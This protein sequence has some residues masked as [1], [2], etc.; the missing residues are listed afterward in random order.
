MDP[1]DLITLKPRLG[2]YVFSLLFVFTGVFSFRSDLLGKSFLADAEVSAGEVT[3]EEVEA[4]APTFTLS[5]DEVSRALRNPRKVKPLPPEVLDPETLWL[6]RCIYSETKRAEEQELVAW[7]VRNRVET[8]YR[9]VQ[10]YRDAV[11][12]DYQF[13]AFNPGSR[14][15]RYY[16]NLRIDSRA[17][18]WKNA[19]YLA[20]YV[21]H[22][23]PSLR[24][25]S[26]ETRHF[27]SE[28]AMQG[29]LHPEWSEGMQPVSPERTFKLDARRFRFF[30]G[31]I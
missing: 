22:A 25:F 7:V 5:A 14:K 3:A 18:G 12:D 21:R 10:T 17:P 2:A 6:A 30:Q 29:R 27:Y 1:R 16:S 13:S 24:P 4:P 8:G 20:H 28:Q 23:D 26:S 11:L 31:V 15:R 9:G 19:L